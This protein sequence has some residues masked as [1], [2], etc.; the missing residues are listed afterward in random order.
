MWPFKR[1]EPDAPDGRF[2]EGTRAIEDGDLARGVEVLA[3]LADE[4]PE[5]LAAA[6]NLGAAYF[7]LGRNEDAAAQFERA[8]RLDP[9]SPRIALNLAAAK[10]A[11][12]EIDEAI[13]LLLRVL[14]MD[15]QYRDCHYNLAIAYWR[16]ERL[17]EAMAELEMEIALHPDHELARRM[18][19]QLRERHGPVGRG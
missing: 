18:A 7:T 2:A 13:D 15:P 1:R 10:S 6:V 17:P 14:E 16:K 19:A 9:D 11:L 4:E 8:H 5:N 3:A 12:D